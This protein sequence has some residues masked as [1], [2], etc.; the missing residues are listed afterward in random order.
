MATPSDPQQGG[1][2]YWSS[3]GRCIAPTQSY[4]TGLVSDSWGTPPTLPPCFD[5]TKLRTHC[6]EV[7]I[8]KGE[9]RRNRAGTDEAISPALQGGPP[10]MLPTKTGF[11]RA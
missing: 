3:C 7:G 10:V 5:R 4:I 2:F 8:R 1:R 6:S 9:A 11:G